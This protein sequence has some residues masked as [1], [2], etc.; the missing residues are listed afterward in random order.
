MNLKQPNMYTDI[1]E[2][3]GAPF[4][5][6]G[7]GFFVYGRNG[8]VHWNLDGFPEQQQTHEYPKGTLW[9]YYDDETQEAPVALSLKNGEKQYV[10]QARKCSFDAGEPSTDFS[11]NVFMPFGHAM[12]QAGETTRVEMLLFSSVKPHDL[13]RTSVPACA[14]EMTLENTSDEEQEY[15]L[16]LS[17]LSGAFT[18]RRENELIVLSQ[19][20][21]EIAFGFE[22]GVGGELTLRVGAHETVR[23]TAA[24]G[25]YYPKFSTPGIA[26]DDIIFRNNKIQNYDAEK[27]KGSYIRNYTLRYDGAASPA[28]EA[29]RDHAL[30]HRDIESW[31][32]SYDVPDAIRHIWFGSYASVIT[33]SLHSTEGFCFE[34]EQPHGCLNTM[35]VSVYCTWLFMVNWPEVE[36][37]DLEQYIAAI[38]T[39]GETA[40]KVWHS[41]W[42]DGAHYVEEAIY[43]IR[44]WRF[45]LWSG[46]LEFLKD[47][48]P[49]VRRALEYMYTA[50]GRGNLIN[51]VGGNQSYDGWMMP[52]IGAYVNIQWIY[53]LFSFRKMCQELGEEPVLCGKKLDS[54]IA[55][56]VREYNDILWD[57]EGGYWHAYKTNETSR[58]QAFGAAIFTDQ[59]FGHWAASLDADSR[60]VLNADREKRAIRKIYQHNRI[61]ETDAGYSCWTNGMMPVREDTYKIDV[62]AT[63]PVACGYHALTCWV[64]TQMN[65]A[66][67]LGY[68]GL[69][70]ESLDV[71]T[72]VSHGMGHNIL[73]VGEWNRM[74]DEKLNPIGNWHEIGKDTPRFPPYPRYKSS[75][76]YLARLLG[77]E[78]TLDTLSLS[79]FSSLDFEVKDIT[80]ANV[81]LT[82]R[83]EKGWTKCLVNGVE[84]S[85]VINRSMGKAVFEFVR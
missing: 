37:R 81:N 17:Y 76:E 60:S 75:W 41:L 22:G 69:E 31:H 5:G 82:V 25:W 67:M 21:G 58:Q 74:T 71:F 59:L 9:K 73:A 80:L 10:L 7:T 65:L 15:T 49:S 68:F 32:D 30:W 66:S 63:D 46:N 8:F 11:M 4:G 52:G 23:A 85:P 42:A 77:V 79:P 84:A 47:A 13:S 48:F 43:A 18:A 19:E 72:Q 26:P 1:S 36:Q 55:D 20:T 35:D 54:F 2:S 53:A 34:I 70:E 78:L 57:E 39:T 61:E 16:S 51:N 12:M 29:I 38:P 56:A 64:S 62:S 3:I 40:G 50:S 28:R 33:A 45:A 27:N 14:F 83:V 44:I 24:L 6:F